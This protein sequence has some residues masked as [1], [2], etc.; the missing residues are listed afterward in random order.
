M[1]IIKALTIFVGRRGRVRYSD[2][3]Y[4]AA[5]FFVATFF[6]A[7]ARAQDP[8]EAQLRLADS[9]YEAGAPFDAATEAKRLL[10]FD[11]TGAKRYEARTLLAASEKAGGNYH[12]AR[13]N[14]TLAEAA[15]RTDA[16]RWRARVEKARVLILERRTDEALRLLAWADTNA[17]TDG[18][19][20]EA[21]Y[22]RGWSEMFADE[23]GAA[24]ETFAEIGSPLERV[25]R[26]VE[27][28]TLSIDAARWLSVV[29]PGAGQTYAGRPLNG[30]LSLGWNALWAWSATNAFLAERIVEG[31]VVA[32][33]LWLRF[34]QGN[35]Q[36]A[37]AFAR[38]ANAAVA[39]EALTYLRH[40]YQGKKP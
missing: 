33:F 26:D 12:E 10:F 18:E 32:N 23:W 40:R 16:E 3:C 21:R 37:V 15:A 39:D 5:T 34:Y 31:A 2:I 6:V 29:V 14:F 25:C 8:Y 27:E 36:N 19:R 11:S 22:W 17:A 7:T 1:L 35:L 30:A 4:I 38:S 24:A 20:R 9:L 28:A 13:R